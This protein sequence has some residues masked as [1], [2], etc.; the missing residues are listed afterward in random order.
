MQKAIS[1]FQAADMVLIAAGAGMSVQA[2]NDYFD[3]KA[4]AQRF[5][6]MLRH[7]FRYPYQLVGNPAL[8]SN[9][10]LQW[11]YMATFINV[12][13]SLPL[14]EVYSK[15]RSAVS[16]KDTWVATTNVDRLFERHGFPAERCF[17]PQGSFRFLQCAKPCS[18]A[19]VF[20]SAPIVE[21]LMPSIDREATMLRDASLIPKC[22]RCGADLFPNVRGGPWFIQDHYLDAGRRMTEWIEAGIEGGRRIC[23]LEIGVGF[24]TPSVLRWPMERLAASSPLASIV[25]VNLEEPG[26]EEQIPAD[27]CASLQVDALQFI[28]SLPQP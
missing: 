28:R 5:P 10:L 8:R 21:R 13:S 23:I 27:R 19:A 20:E 16:R 17:T 26:F 15:L 25:R 11:G 4:F 22:D 24:N 12:V 6:G 3:E 14:S 7:G 2:G 18:A 9:P 1:L